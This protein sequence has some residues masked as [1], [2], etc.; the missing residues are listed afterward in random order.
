MSMVAR[1]VG[2][3]ARYDV[4]HA[5]E[6][7]MPWPKNHKARTRSDIV[8]A[9]AAAF[10]A[11]GLAGV[12][13][14]ELMASTGRTHGGF[15]AHFSSKEDLLAA[16]LE[17]ASQQTIDALSRTLETLPAAQRLQAVIDT[18]LSPEHAAHPERGCPVAA[19]GSELG[20]A[21]ARTRRHIARSVRRRLEWLHGL[22]SAGNGS[23]VADDQVIGALAC[24]VGGLI[25]ARLIGGKDSDVVLRACREFLHRAID[26]APRPPHSPQGVASQRKRSKGVRRS[27]G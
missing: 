24:M 15:Y 7:L 13:L 23:R 27:R 25:V 22:E 26:K 21:G 12:R 11:R 3:V 4:N 18:Y 6:V 20:R 17:L 9:A 19:L 8:R 10:R 14:D 2:G 1:R 16:A 5:E